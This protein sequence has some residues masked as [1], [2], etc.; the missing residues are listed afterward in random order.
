VGFQLVNQTLR[1]LH[2]NQQVLARI[3][4]SHLAQEVTPLLQ[5]ENS[6]AQA[7]QQLA[8]SYADN[9]SIHDVVFY[10][11]EGDTLAQ[12]S[13]AV[14]VSVVLDVRGETP[15]VMDVDQEAASDAVPAETTVDTPLTGMEASSAA[16]EGLTPY[17]ATIGAPDAPLGYVRVTINSAQL[18]A[19]SQDYLDY[20][21]NAL[22]QLGLGILAISFLLTRALSGKRYRW[23]TYARRPLWLAHQAPWA[24]GHWRK[25]QPAANPPQ[26]SPSPASGQDVPAE[27]N[28]DS[29]P[30]GNPTDKTAGTRLASASSNDTDSVK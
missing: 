1:Y 20:G 19:L 21:Y 10:N 23:M 30:I 9:T 18:W 12:S 2:A 17:I 25:K 11:A 16:T 15:P 29:P 5:H 4:S 3:L 7:L 24:I 22:L 6:Q 28:H 26:P 27:P 14:P 13:Q 8:E